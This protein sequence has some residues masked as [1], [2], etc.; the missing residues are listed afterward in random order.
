MAVVSDRQH[1]VGLAGG[2]M[3]ALAQY[4]ALGG[5]EVSGSDR[6]FDAGGGGELRAALERAGI[7]AYPQD[8]SGVPGA[9]SV[10]VS[11]AIEDDN[12]ELARARALGIP[13]RHRTDALAEEVARRRTVAVAGTSGKSTVTAMIYEI[14][15]ADGRDPSL[16]TGAPLPSLSARGLVGNA[17]RGRSELL[18]I[19]ADESDGTLPKYRPA[20]GV[21]LNMGK[22]HKELAELHELFA[23]F[24]ARAGHFVLNADAQN[25]SG[26][27]AG[28]ATFGFRTGELRGSGLTLEPA[29]CSFTVDGTRIELPWPGRHNA[30]NALAAIAACRALGVPVAACARALARF[31]GVARRFQSVGRAGGVEVID[32][33]AHNPDKVRAALAAAHLRSPRVL[34]V[35]QPHGFFPA[36]FM[37]AELIDA[38]A[39]SLG[40]ADILWMPAIYY[41]GGTAAKDIDSGRIAGPVRERGRDARYVPDRAAIIP[42]LAAEARPGDLALVL[43]ARDPGLPE[44]ARALLAALAARAEQRP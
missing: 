43:G 28:A 35:F 10:L 8:G 6:L 17:A 25:L 33:F 7:R 3:S 26:L 2:G 30:E 40:P 32:D 44:F 36:R 34:C 19:E 41:A 27:S 11:T 20:V 31:G 24:R 38:F 5:A 12:A 42:E 14:L 4:A 1:F 13:I 21:L 29:R 18:V 37:R 15:A 22:D 23:G 16:I 9:G 39:D